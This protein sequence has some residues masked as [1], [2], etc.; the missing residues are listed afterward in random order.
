MTS[1]PW[2]AKSIDGPNRKRSVSSSWLAL[3][4]LVLSLIF[5]ANTAS[6]LQTTSADVVVYGGTSAGV[7]AAVQCA[8]MG[9]TVVLVEPGK[10]LGGLTSGALGATDIGNKAAIGGLSREYYRMVKQHYMQ[11]PAWVFEVADKFARGD[12]NS[13]SDAMWV[14]EP[15]VAEAIMDRWVEHES[16]AVVRQTRLNRTDGVRKTGTVIQSIESD[17]GRVFAAKQFIDATYEGDLMASAGVSFTIGREANSV[18]RETLNGVQ[19]ARAIH[20]QLQP[21]LDPFRIPGD[22]ASGLLPDINAQPPATDGSGDRLVQTYNIR[23]CATNEPKNRVAFEKPDGYDPIHYELLLRNFEAGEKRA[24]W[25]PLMMPNLKTDANNNFGVSTDFIG[26]SHQWAEADYAT[27]DRIYQEHLDWTRGLMWTLANNERVPEQLR[28]E[29]SRWGTCRDEFMDNGGWSHQLYVR[30]A[31][32]MVSDYV[33]TQ[34]NCQGKTVAEHPVG[35]A[36]YTMDSHNVQRYVDANG[37]VRNEGDVQ[38]GGFPPYPIAWESIL[39]RRTECTNLTVPVSLSASHIAY[40][41]IRMEPV[42]MVLAQS[43]ATAACIAIDENVTLHDLDYSKL[44]SHLDRDKQ[45]LEWN[46]K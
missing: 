22:P 14:F 12:L 19:T 33:M 36:A 20:H 10:H 5:G 41:S 35:L 27:R 16:I 2:A 4:V 30:E 21:G 39:P 17:D 24:P 45:V 11:E 42:F 1:M 13:A 8:R 31:R 25:N 26:H 46:R 3:T 32:R 23:I 9:K 29:F 18:H 7:V 44:K 15:H 40:G 34:S 6:G 38:V 43:A 28:Q 37:H